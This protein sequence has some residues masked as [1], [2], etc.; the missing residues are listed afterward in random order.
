MWSRR[1]YQFD[2]ERSKN[3]A[4]SGAERWDTETQG[5]HAGRVKFRG[6]NIHHVEDGCDGEFTG[7]DDSKCQHGRT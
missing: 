2:S 5:P 4:D 3:G 1:A 7:S 6:E